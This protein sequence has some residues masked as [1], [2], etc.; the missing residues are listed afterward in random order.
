[1]TKRLVAMLLGTF[2]ATAASHAEIPCDFK[3]VSIGDKMT[4]TELMTALGIKKYELNAPVTPWYKRAELA[5]KY[6]ISAS[7]EIIDWETGPSC[8]ETSC[9]IPYGV[10]VGNNNTP[11]GIFISF[12]QGL[13]TEID[14]SFNETYWDEVLPILQRKYGRDWAIERDPEMTITNLEDR[15]HTTV[16]RITMTH[17]T[18]GRNPK[19]HDSC[20]LSA[21][22]FDVAFQ[23]HDPLGS[24]HS[25]FVIKLVSKNF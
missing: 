25:V 1:L 22:N 7:A 18:G 14:V 21:T 4:P 20:R 2:L 12:R 24:F 6:G 16:E 3:G 19:T 15:G 9:Q 10:G 17:H 8:D 5:K 13:I 23:H 11:V